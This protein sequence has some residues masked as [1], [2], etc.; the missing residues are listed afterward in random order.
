M[1]HSAHSG[2]THAAGAVRSHTVP[3]TQL[4]GVNVAQPPA[5]IEHVPIVEPDSQRVGLPSH[6]GAQ[7]VPAPG[8]PRHAPLAHVTRGPVS[9]RHANSSW[10]HDA[11]VLGETQVGPAVVQ[12]RSSLQ[13][14]RA[15]P[16][17]V[18]QV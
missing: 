16:P 4:D 2:S 18:V 11:S 3:A 12:A 17:V 1:G 5:P 7:Q 13:T 9:K 10:A 6:E 14:H 8:A 15:G